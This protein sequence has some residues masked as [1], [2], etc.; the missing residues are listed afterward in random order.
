[1]PRDIVPQVEVGSLTLNGLAAFTPLIAALTADNVQPAAM[2]QLEILGSCFHTSGK[3]AQKV[4]DMLQRCS[5][6]RLDHLGMTLGWRKGGAASAMAQS[7]GG[8]AIAL[9][10]FCLRN[11]YNSADCGEVLLGLSTRVLQRHLSICSIAQLADVADVLAGKLQ[12]L[13]FGNFLA[14][15]IIRIHKIFQQLDRP[16]PP[17]FLDLI[18]RESMVDFLTSLSQA[19]CEERTLVRIVGTQ[20]MG[21]IVAVV[22]ILFPTDTTLTFGDLIVQEGPGRLIYLE[23]KDANEAGRPTQI[24]IEMVVKRGERNCFP[25]TISPKTN[26]PAESQCFFQ[27][28]GHVADALHIMFAGFG[29][30]CTPALIAACCDVLIFLPGMISLKFGREKYPLN[31]RSQGEEGPSKSLLSLLGPEPMHRMYQ[32]C[33]L[34]LRETPSDKPKDGSSAYCHLVQAFNEA[35]GKCTLAGYDEI[36]F[37]TKET[38]CRSCRSCRLWRCVENSI[39]RGFWCFFVDAGPNA[40]IEM[41]LAVRY[42][43]FYGISHAISGLTGIRH[44]HLS[45]YKMHGYVMGLINSRGKLDTSN[46]ASS[47]RSS[48]LCHAS[49]LQIE[50]R[51]GEG[52]AYELREGQILV[53]DRYYLRLR[54]VG[55]KQRP[56]ASNSLFNF[57]GKIT[58]SSSGE[59]SDLVF[60]IRESVEAAELRTTAICQGHSLHLSL[61]LIII[62]SLCLQVA[63]PCDHDPGSTLDEVHSRDVFTTSI[64]APRVENDTKTVAITQTKGNPIA[65]LLAC[66]GSAGAILQRGCCLNCA[67]EQAR[68]ERVGQIIVG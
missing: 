47:N 15:Q 9:L 10:C 23:F 13:G 44:I 30:A 48:T 16:V 20:G 29:V 21:Y 4:P 32:V 5:S 65:Q 7:A 64:V 1:M 27:W 8:Q 56:C 60:T 17:D 57:K 53:N 49:L 35:A 36:S 14:E 41:D 42:E 31:K 58:P 28:T 26:P 66:E 11:L 55:A 22:A 19:F 37:P 54:S 33:N 25:I 34:V 12:A 43:A 24:E 38:R 59:H 6:T 18:S 52:V 61:T 40:I 2:I 50:R 67:V 39:S 45:D 63:D 62:S 51:L 68:A 3:F 46:L